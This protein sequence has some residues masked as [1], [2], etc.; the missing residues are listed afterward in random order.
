MCDERLTKDGVGFRVI[1]STVASDE[2]TKVVVVDARFE[3]RSNLAPECFGGGRF[4]LFFR[5][6]CRIRSDFG[7][8]FCE[9]GEDRIVLPVSYI[10]VS[11]RAGGMEREERT[12]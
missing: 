8:V 1:F 10:V 6:G 3:L 5:H 2:G 9:G 12:K 7:K 4:E 11:G